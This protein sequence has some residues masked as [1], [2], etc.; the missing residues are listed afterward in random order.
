MK[1]LKVENQK[2][3]SE[4]DSLIGSVHVSYESSTSLLFPISL[5]DKDIELDLIVR[6][7]LV[8]L[9]LRKTESGRSYLVEVVELKFD[10]PIRAYI[11]MLCGFPE[12]VVLDFNDVEEKSK[13]NYSMVEL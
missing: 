1:L 10:T 3:N 9:L 12:L 11:D 13:R 6:G 8:S 5:K 4:A 7:N 2:T